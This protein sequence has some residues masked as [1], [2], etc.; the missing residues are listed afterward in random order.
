MHMYVHTDF[1]RLL[2]VHG[3]FGMY[4]LRSSD[5]GRRGLS[6]GSGLGTGGVEKAV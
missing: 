4:R 1:P 6:K 2:G 5:V 3:V